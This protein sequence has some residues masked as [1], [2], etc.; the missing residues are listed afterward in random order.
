M[1]GDQ[2]QPPKGLVQ[3][4]RGRHQQAEHADVDWL[5]DSLDQSH[6]M[7]VRQPRQAD[8]G[9]RLP[10]AFVDVGAVVQHIGMR[11]QHASR[12]GS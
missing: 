11:H 5:E 4:S 9:A 7:E 1:L 3:E 8:A 10:E 12:R 6:V 2:L